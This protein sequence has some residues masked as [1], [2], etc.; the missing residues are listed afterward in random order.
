MDADRMFELAQALA[1]AKSRQDLPAAMQ[2]FDPEMFGETAA[3][4]AA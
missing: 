4:V 1:M 2:L 3:P